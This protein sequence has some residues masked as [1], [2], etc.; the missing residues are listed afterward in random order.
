L[1]GNVAAS[2]SKDFG[3]IGKI[4]ANLVGFDQNLG[5]VKA[6]SGQK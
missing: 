4:W 1:L 5:K 3:K 2:P 6:K